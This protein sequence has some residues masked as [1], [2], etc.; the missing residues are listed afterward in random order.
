[1]IDFTPIQA[2]DYSRVIEL[3]PRNSHAHHNRGISHDKKGEFQQAIADFSR[4]LELD[5]TNAN[6]FFNRGSTHDALG[7]YDKVG[8]GCARARSALG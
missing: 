6:A 4:V 8:G 3:D 1:M 5:Q 2:R 7:A